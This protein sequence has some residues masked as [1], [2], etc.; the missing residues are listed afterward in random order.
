[1]L[2]LIAGG[3]QVLDLS[4]AQALAIAPGCDPEVLC[5]FLNQGETYLGNHLA[6][7]NQQALDLGALTGVAALTA[8][9]S[10]TLVHADGG[11]HVSPPGEHAGHGGPGGVS[12]PHHGSHEAGPLATV[13]SVLP[14]TGGFWSGLIGVALILLGGGAMLLAWER[15][16]SALV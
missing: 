12:A 11:E 6:G 1:V 2:D 3:N 7:H 16:T 9:Q 15:R 5:V 10:E 4:Q 8:G 13:A 14:N